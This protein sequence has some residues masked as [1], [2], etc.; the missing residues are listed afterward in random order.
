MGSLAAA[1]F[2][3]R[4]LCLLLQTCLQLRLCLWLLCEWKRGAWARRRHSRRRCCHWPAGARARCL[5]WLS[6]P[7]P[8]RLPGWGVLPL[9]PLM[10]LLPDQQGRLLLLLL[11]PVLVCRNHK[12]TQ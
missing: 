11:L 7:M 12:Q 2:G 8:L 9:V 5:P 10:L 1:S 6:M 3:C 4:R